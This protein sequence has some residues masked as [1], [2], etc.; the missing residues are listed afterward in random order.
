MRLQGRKVRLIH[1]LPLCRPSRVKAEMSS[2]YFTYLTMMVTTHSQLFV[3][4]VQSFLQHGH[5][6]QHRSHI[7][8]WSKT[9]PE[10]I[11]KTWIQ[12]SGFLLLK[13]IFKLAR[14]AGLPMERSWHLRFCKMATPK[15]MF[16]SWLTVVWCVLQTTKQLTLNQVGHQTVSL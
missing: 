6:I 10:S 7:Q 14:Q 9:A 3:K 11:F 12:V 5:R 8:F 16:P 2:M 15:F 4:V 13:L 1:K